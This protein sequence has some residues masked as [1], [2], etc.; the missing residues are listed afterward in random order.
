[1]EFSKARLFG[2]LAEIERL[3]QGE[4]PYKHSQEAL[5]V[6]RRHF[7]NHI[8]ALTVLPADK[9]PAIV[10]DMCAEALY[11]IFENMP[12][13]GFLLRSTNVRNAFEVY[14]PILRLARRIISPKTK[15]IL[16]SEWEFSPFTF[17]YMPPLP[18][19][20][21]IGIPASESENPLV[22]PL[23]GHELGH[24]LWAAND[25]DKVFYPKVEDAM[26]SVL[27]LRLAELNKLYPG[28]VIPTA[29]PADLD[30]NIP[31]K[32]YIAASVE[33]ALAQTQEYFCDAVGLYLFDEAFLHA[34]AYLLAPR[35]ACP[36]TF[37]YPNTR[38]R[39]ASLTKAAAHFRRSKPQ[40]YSVPT[41]YALQF[42]DA[43]EP[44]DDDLRF[45]VS[46][47]DAAA[48]KL[49]AALYRVVAKLMK[50]AQVPTL[51]PSTKV[52]ILRDYR[53]V[54][55]CPSSESLTNIINA[56]WDV[57][58][59]PHFWPNISDY[60]SKMK[61]LRDVVLKNIELLEIE[62]RAP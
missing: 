52:K 44:Q 13:L 23:A 47:A 9:D 30:V 20:V 38:P 14:G 58:N 28:I 2:V 25:M 56:A 36:R 50:K 49:G 54:V 17:R 34:Y 59:Q 7:Q 22:L 61:M 35:A 12:L 55:P 18:D 51:N 45:R 19:H 8:D 41:N 32:E 53:L 60:K 3:E 21:F 29:S 40:L 48:S 26:L 39:I 62:Q 5:G 1:M 16:S 27:A 42:E 6:L 43:V 57:F 4:F 31:V 10:A 15:L 37:D 46:L 33:W 24:T 11:D